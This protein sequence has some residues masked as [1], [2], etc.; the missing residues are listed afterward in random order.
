[1]PLTPLWCWG[2]GSV[3]TKNGGKAVVGLL[4]EGLQPTPSPSCLHITVILTV[5]VARRK[6]RWRPMH[7]S[8]IFDGIA[9]LS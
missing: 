4:T 8:L 5:A 9:L 7:K 6:P 3:R 2:S 1:V